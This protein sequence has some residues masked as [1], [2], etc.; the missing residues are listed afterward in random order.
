[1]SKFPF[2]L[3]LIISAMPISQLGAAIIIQ[4]GSFESTSVAIT[5]D[6]LNPAF[7]DIAAANGLNSWTVTNGSGGTNTSAGLANGDFGASQPPY[8]MGNDS[9]IAYQAPQ[10]GNTF[11]GSTGAGIAILSQ[12]ISGLTDPGQFTVSFYT[13][14][15]F[16][17]GGGSTVG[18]A[19]QFEIFEGTDDSGTQIFNETVDVTSQAQETWTLNSYLTPVATSSQDLYVRITTT[20]NAS[21]ALWGLDNVIIDYTAVP[22]P[23]S[24]VL[25]GLAGMG[26]LIRRRR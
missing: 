18:L 3:P 16:A 1:M 6:T 12:Q 8:V 9:N 26:L 15:M 2:V 22:E 21:A 13:N 24:T 23:S 19:I 14:R 11:L 4:N 5:P 10:D 25:I 20:D 17:D 7:G